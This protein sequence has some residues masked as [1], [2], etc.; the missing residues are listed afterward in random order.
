MRNR[1]DKSS[2]AQ[3]LDGE[4]SDGETAG[5]HAH[6][7]KPINSDAQPGNPLPR[8]WFRSKAAFGHD[9]RQPR[10]QQKQEDHLAKRGVVEP[11]IE[12]EA[13]PQAG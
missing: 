4:P 2:V 8:R 6:K 5:P 9:Q 11:A 3:L 13:A 1:L 12:L 7:A 10:H